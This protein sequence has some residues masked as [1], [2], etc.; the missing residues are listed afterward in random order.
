MFYLRTDITH[1]ISISIEKLRRRLSYGKRYM[2][3]IE[4]IEQPITG[5]TLWYG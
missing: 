5:N 1:H 3:R 2:E 4:I